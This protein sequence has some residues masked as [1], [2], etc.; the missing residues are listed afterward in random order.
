MRL[1][2]AGCPLVAFTEKPGAKRVVLHAY[3]D[4]RGAATALAR[5]WGGCVETVDVRKWIKAQPAPPTRIGSRLE[6]IHEKSRTRKQTGGAQLHVPH[7]L[8]FGSGE[9]GTTFMLLREL[10]R[11]GDWSATTVLD[12]GTGSGVLALAARLFGAKKIVATDFDPES[13]RTARQNEAINFAQPL[14]RWQQQDVKKLRPATRYDLVLAN[15]FS[16]IL[17]EAAPQIAGSVAPGGELWLSGILQAQEEEV[18]AA[19]R[20]QGMQLIQ[21]RRRGKWVMLLLSCSGGL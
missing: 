16:G 5:K 12:L 21:A 3:P 18:V 7:G 20:G 2:E 9:H 14:I 17:E 13:V 6:I 15:L 10:T 19:Y 11:R 1:Q 8:A 4:S